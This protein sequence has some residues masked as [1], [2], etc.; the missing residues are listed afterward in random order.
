MHLSLSILLSVFLSL[1]LPLSLCLCLSPSP[2]LLVVGVDDV[3]SRWDGSSLQQLLCL[4]PLGKSFQETQLIKVLCHSLS[5][6]MALSSCL[7]HLP[8]QIALVLQIHPEGKT[9]RTMTWGNKTIN[10]PLLKQKNQYVLH[11]HFNTS[12]APSSGHAVK[13]NITEHL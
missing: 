11:T 9:G 13:K 5:L 1:R 4:R 2:V 7:G 3:V 6:L 8:L 10:K 12:D